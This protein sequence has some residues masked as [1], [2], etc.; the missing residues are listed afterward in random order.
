MNKL[1]N[2]GATEK[3]ISES[4]LYP[5]LQLARVIAQYKSLYRVIAKDTEYLA[6]ISGK[7]NY[8]VTELSEYP[9]VGDFV[10]INLPISDNSNAIIYKTLSR[11]S[12]FERKST[13]DGYKTQ[14]L[15]TNIDIIF[16]CMSLNNDYSLNRL[17]R[18]LSIAWSSGATPIVLL[19]KSDLCN[20]LY[21]K[22]N[23]IMD[24]ALGC[25]VIATSVY[26]NTSYNKLLNYLS[27]GKTAVFIGSSGVGK[28]TLINKLIGNDNL[29]TAK[30]RKDDKGRHTTTN[31]ELFLLPCGGIVIDTPGIREVGIETGNFSKSFA[32]IDELS[33]KCRFSDCTHTNEPGC[34][35]LAAVKS[36]E[37]DYRRLENYRKLKRE[38]KYD[39][40]S[41]KELE[42]EKFNSMFKEVGGMKRVRKYVRENDKRK[43]QYR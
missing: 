7:Y 43:K 20:D 15:A 29:K 24:I 14:I 21:N 33:T 11:H 6:E 1:S 41:S 34:A 32:D 37:I 25:D 8:E 23:E 4:K 36:G 19:T 16:I 3:I 27:H 12:I 17:E 2:Y 39:G 18:Y 42:K 22:T 40:L 9:S 28:S 35:V 26:D 10:M 30:I 31:K 38:A 13:D 5:N